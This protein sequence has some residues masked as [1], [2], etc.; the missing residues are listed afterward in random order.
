MF[1]IN[2]LDLVKQLVIIV[3][4]ILLALVFGRKISRRSTANINLDLFQF[5]ENNFR[6]IYSKYHLVGQGVHD[7]LGAEYPVF[8]RV[9][10]NALRKIKSLHNQST[11]LLVVMVSL[12][13]FIIISTR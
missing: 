2:W 1:D 8:K 10:K 11:G 7:R 6:H 9:E 12:I 3:I 13:T 5:I 4:G